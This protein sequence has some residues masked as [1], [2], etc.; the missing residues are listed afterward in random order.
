MEQL[1]SAAGSRFGMA[2]A[3]L[4]NG[5]H[6]GAIRTKAIQAFARKL[7]STAAPDFV[8]WASAQ[9]LPEE[10]NP[11]LS[12][13]GPQLMQLSVETLHSLLQDT[14]NSESKKFTARLFSEKAAEQHGLVY[15][16]TQL[17]HFPPEVTQEGMKHGVQTLAA[18]DIWDTVEQA[19]KVGLNPELQTLIADKA[20]QADPQRALKFYEQVADGELRQLLLMQAATKWLTLD[21]NAAS[22]WAANVKDD[23]TR[24]IAAVAVCRHLLRVGGST[25]EEIA[26]L[27][28]WRS[29]VSDPMLLQLIRP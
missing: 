9:S 3:A 23:R 20:V 27:A 16:Q 22:T 1:F 12:A 21:S 28:Q 15:L 19:G 17:A 24:Q 11:A 18:R 26:D 6:A 2:G 13:I 4:L 25:P 7:P 10:L 29:Q 14:G 5:L 8:K